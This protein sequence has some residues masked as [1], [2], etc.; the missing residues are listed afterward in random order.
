MMG[1]GGFVEQIDVLLRRA[2]FFQWI[3]QNGILKEQE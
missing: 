2:M 1:Y 3:P